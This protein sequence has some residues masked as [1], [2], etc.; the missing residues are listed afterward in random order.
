MRYI[1]RKDIW[2]TDLIRGEDN[3][4]DLVWNT[5]IDREKKIKGRVG[6][7]GKIGKSHSQSCYIWYNIN[8]C[9]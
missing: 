6:L 7:G 2:L 5:A 8:V 3:E 1:D 4:R 9:E